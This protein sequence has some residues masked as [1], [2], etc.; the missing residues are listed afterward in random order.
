MNTP[1]IQADIDLDAIAVNIREL[2]KVAS[3][4]A[5]FMAVV[6]ANAYGHGAVEVARKALGSGAHCLGV[7]RAEEA[8]ALRKAGIDA[9]IIVLGYTPPELT[10]LALDNYLTLTVFD[11]DTAQAISDV[12][13]AAGKTVTAH[14]KT[15]TG[16]GRLGLRPA[17]ESGESIDPDRVKTAC[18]IARMPGLDL[19]GIFTHFAAADSADTAYTTKQ[20]ELFCDYVEKLRTSGIEFRLKHAAN[21]AAILAHPRTHLDM[22]RAGIAMYGL[23]PSAQV[24]LDHLETRPVMALKT[25]LVHVKKVSKGFCVS[26][27]MTHCTTAPTTIATVPLG[28]ADGYSR[29]LSSR[30]QM[31]VGGIR[32]PIVGRVCMDLTMLDVGKV[33]DLKPGDEVVAFG[34]QQET[35]ISADELAASLGTINY[36]IVSSLTARVPKIHI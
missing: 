13:V 1:L 20:F 12:A 2:K 29:R 6:K 5:R 11:A 19:E 9:R 15:D 4:T 24:N 17:G 25:C 7:A 34:R 16:M 30:G 21:S 32:V 8:V 31:L 26:Y 18:R 35:E 27:G 22:V 36:E 33:R 10:R 23:N 28:Y 14:I 3:P